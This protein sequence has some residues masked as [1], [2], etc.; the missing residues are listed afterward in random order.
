MSTT[1]TTMPVATVDGMSTLEA[2]GALLRTQ[3]GPDATT[4]EVVV[5]LWRK[6][7]LLDLIAARNELPSETATEMA[8]AA[9]RRAATLVGGAP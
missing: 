2:L 3:P 8:S 6:A 7:D 4:V 5:W 1:T 9:R